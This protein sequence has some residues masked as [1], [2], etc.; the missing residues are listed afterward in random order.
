MRAIII[1]KSFVLGFIAMRD[2]YDL[3]DKIGTGDTEIEAL[4]ML[5]LLEEKIAL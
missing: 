4:E 1:E 5:L 2:E 3:G